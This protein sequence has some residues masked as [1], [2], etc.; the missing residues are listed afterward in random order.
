MTIRTPRTRSVASLALAGLL[1]LGAAACSAEQQQSVR[2]S[3]LEPVAEAASLRISD[4]VAAIDVDPE[5]AGTGFTTLAE[6]LTS[7]AAGG[8]DG[9]QETAESAAQAL[10]ELATVAEEGTASATDTA[11]LEEEAKRSLAALV[12]GC[13]ER[14][15]D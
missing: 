8:P 6:G 12:E 5:V 1:L 15:E 14:L 13:N 9:L 3:A 7:A 11:A 10:R 2:C 4:L